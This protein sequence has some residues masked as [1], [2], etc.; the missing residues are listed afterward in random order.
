MNLQH[1]NTKYK[2]IVLVVFIILLCISCIKPVYPSEM[3]LQHFITVIMIVIL[4]IIIE[5]NSL[6]DRSFTLIVAFLALHIIGA[7]WIYSYVP[8]KEWIEAVA[9]KSLSGLLSSGRNN[10]DRFVHLMFGFMIL[11]P[12]RE[13]YVKWFRAPEKFAG[14]LA[15]LSILGISLVYEVF[16]WGLTLV[17][18]PQDAEDY[19]GQQGD[20]WDAQKDMALAMAG[21]LLALIITLVNRIRLRRLHIN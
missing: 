19:N 13:I 11:Y 4:A 2:I 16:E 8:Y 6:S 18:S 20:M 1:R 12:L 15:F 9:G 10:Y 3:F 14:I 7:R 17:L 21:A 5:N